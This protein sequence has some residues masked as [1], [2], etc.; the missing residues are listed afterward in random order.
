[1]TF[2]AEHVT[3]ILAAALGAFGVVLA[4]ALAFLGAWL[5]VRGDRSL[6]QAEAEAQRQVTK[7][8]IDAQIDAR[9]RGELQD[10]WKRIDALEAEQKA[11]KE[12]QSRVRAAFARILRAIAAQWPGP[13]APNLDPADIDLLGDTMP[14]HWIRPKRG[15]S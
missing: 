10:A 4:A 6:A 9:V 2:A 12:E 3:Q 8:Q 14:P 5:K 7:A 15:T 11:Q 13:G 1:M